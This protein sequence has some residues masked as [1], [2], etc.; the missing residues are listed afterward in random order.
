MRYRL[1]FKN[2][3]IPFLIAYKNDGLLLWDLKSP[4]LS[5]IIVIVD[6][7]NLMNRLLAH[8]APTN[9]N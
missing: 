8:I 9:F 4:T 6:K 3:F 1:N 5:R 2:T 7:E